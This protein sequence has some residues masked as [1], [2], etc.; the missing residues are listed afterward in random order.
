MAQPAA[1]SFGRIAIWAIF[2]L[3]ILGAGLLVALRR[4]AWL[5]RLLPAILLSA[6]TT[7]VLAV[8]VG[9]TAFPMPILPYE[10][11]ES[12][13]LVL[14]GAVLVSLCL[15][16][17]VGV[18]VSAGLAI[19]AAW[20]AQLWRRRNVLDGLQQNDTKRTATR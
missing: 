8:C 5:H 16:F 14:A 18:V 11:V 7:A 9:L 4:S 19:P 2:A 1:F 3:P 15:G 13:G 20:I 6:T 12:P 10:T 17:G